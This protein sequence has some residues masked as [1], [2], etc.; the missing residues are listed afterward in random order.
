MSVVFFLE[1]GH[2][3]FL[4]TEQQQEQAEICHISPIWMSALVPAG[5]GLSVTFNFLIFL[6]VSDV[7]GLGNV[8]MVNKC[9]TYLILVLGSVNLSLWKDFMSESIFKTHWC[10]WVCKEVHCRRR[11]A[12]P[13]V[14][15]KKRLEDN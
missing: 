2:P 5:S 14:T 7:S 4:N 8:A 9:Y 15:N 10:I 12:E 3:Q 6:M 1:T 13:N 11:K